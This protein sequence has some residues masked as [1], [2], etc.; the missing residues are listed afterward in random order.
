MAVI[1]CVTINPVQLYILMAWNNSLLE[2]MM[3][4]AGRELQDESKL[5]QIVENADW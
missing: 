2:S 4:L 1:Y 3:R 5:Q